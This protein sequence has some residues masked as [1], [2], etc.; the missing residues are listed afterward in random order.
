[1]LNPLERLAFACRTCWDVRRVSFGDVDGE[2]PDCSSLTDGERS[3]RLRAATAER[4][5]KPE[6]RE[7]DL[8]SQEREEYHRLRVC[9]PEAHP[10]TVLAWIEGRRYDP[11]DDAEFLA[12]CDRRL[13]KWRFTR[14]TLHGP[15]P[16]W[17]RAALAGEPVKLNE[18]ELELVESRRA[19]E[20]EVA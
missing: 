5:P 8:T 10:L 15:D 7:G 14:L 19:A 6:I 1:M 13:R 4:T 20:K 17:L 3:E 2:C 18:S 16:G 9:H 11:R 12:L